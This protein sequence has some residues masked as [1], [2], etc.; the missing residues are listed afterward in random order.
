MSVERPCY[1]TYPGFEAG[2]LNL[3][4]SFQ[5]HDEPERPVLNRKGECVALCTHRPD[6]TAPVT[7]TR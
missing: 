7:Q 6:P 2:D 3:L 4:W 5:R 1:Y